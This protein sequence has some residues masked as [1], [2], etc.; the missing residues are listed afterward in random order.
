MTAGAATPVDV[1]DSVDGWIDRQRLAEDHWDRRPALLRAPRARGHAVPFDSHEVFEGAVAASHHA[2]ADTGERVRFAVG[3]RLLTDPGDLL[4]RPEDGSFA[5]YD[6]RLGRQLG[7]TP[8]ALVVR[9]LHARHHPLWARERAFLA[10]LWDAIGRPQAPIG[11][12]LCHGTCTPPRPLPSRPSHHRA[13]TFLYVLHGRPQLRLTGPGDRHWA[14]TAVPGDLLYWPADHEHAV[15]VPRSPTT[16]VHITVPRTPASLLNHASPH[17][18]W[19][20][21]DTLVPQ[22]EPPDDLPDTLPP[23]VAAALHHLRQEARPTPLHRRL[24]HEVLRQAT[25]G[26]LRPAPAPTRPGYFTDDDAVRATE[27][28]LWMPAGGQRLVAACGHVT[29]TG[30]TARELGALITR[31]NDGEPLPVSELTPPA[32]RLLARLA[33][34]R[35]VERL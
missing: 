16:T 30:L 12:T 33:A 3:P 13:A 18:T 23:A 26:G 10:G 8:F 7:D 32:R 19:G 24:A 25:D 9:E 34:F 14:A 6:R 27:R 22:S 15:H 2:T 4:P 21:V 17:G 5:A 11:T 29:R 20:S 31:L 35:A 28:V 1:L